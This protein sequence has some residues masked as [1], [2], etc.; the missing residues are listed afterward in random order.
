MLGGERV[1]CAHIQAVKIGKAISKD[2]HRTGLRL[3]KA[4]L[5][6]N[7]G[8]GQIGKAIHSFRH[9][10]KKHKINNRSRCKAMPPFHLS[11]CL[12][13]N[14]N[15]ESAQGNTSSMEWRAGKQ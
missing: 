3:V 1:A 13:G 15:H 5:V 2:R 6:P 9:G 10:R 11:S 12:K 4:L 7:S 8:S 14:F